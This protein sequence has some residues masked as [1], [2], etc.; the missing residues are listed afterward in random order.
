MGIDEKS[1][2]NYMRAGYCA[3]NIARRSDG[4]EE[5][6][7]DEEMDEGM[8]EAVESAPA[9]DIDY[10]QLSVDYFL[11]YLEY[12][13]D[14]YK[15]LSEV[16]YTYLYSKSD[17]T[18][19]VKYYEQLAVLAPDSCMAKRSLGYAYFGGVCTKKYTKALGYLKD[20]YNCITAEANDACGDVN[21]TLWV[22]QCYHLR[23]A[24][25][26]GNEQNA[27]DDFKA[28]FNWYGKVLKCEPANSVAKKGQDDVRFEFVD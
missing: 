9:V 26:V 18:N 3:L 23:A 1:I 20:A 11:K 2:S 22:A 10:Y 8:D 6:D 28:A 14:D 24:E 16:A 5:E 17:C 25:K 15:I 21:L 12:K 4:D 27:N 7:I 19:G 13:P